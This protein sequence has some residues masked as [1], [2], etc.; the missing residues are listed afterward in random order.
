MDIIDKLFEVQDKEYAA[1]QA[2]LTPTVPA[3]KF[4]GVRMP[5]V[6]K[7]VKTII[8]EDDYQHFFEQLP[9][10]YYDENIIHGL[11]ISEV[12]DY[13]TC[14]ALLDSFL[15]YI[16]NWAVCD[17]TSPKVFKKN[18]SLLIDKI[19]EWSA[20]KETYTCRFGIKMLMTHFL[21]E[22]FKAE[23]L[24]I[25][26]VIRSE[27]YYVRMMVAW[28]FATALAKQWDEVI[29]YI[30][31]NRLDEWTHNKTIQKAKESYRITK[32]QKEYLNTL[33]RKTI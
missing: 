30:E 13:D 17:T 31:N 21:D 6:R 20:S 32:E 27:E 15:P 22:D 7:L 10:E 5:E 18:K 16:D 28:F 4:I 25:P 11:L 24:E 9:H 1:F 2:K 8:K 26:A 3:E 14:I 33:K 23:Y 19:C 12:K 29:P